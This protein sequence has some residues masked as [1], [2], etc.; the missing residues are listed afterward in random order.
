MFE[1]HQKQ[2]TECIKFQR[3]VQWQT[4]KISFHNARGIQNIHIC[5]AETNRRVD[6]TIDF[7]D[8]KLVT[9][10]LAFGLKSWWDLTFQIKFG[11]FNWEINSEFFK[12]SLEFLIVPILKIVISVVFLLSTLNSSS[13]IPH[14]TE[15]YTCIT[16]KRSALP[17]SIPNFDFPHSHSCLSLV[18]KKKIQNLF[19]DTS[20][21][22][23]NYPRLAPQ[24]LPQLGWTSRDMI[25]SQLYIIGY[26]MSHAIYT[27][28]GVRFKC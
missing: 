13:L 17:C 21:A 24:W 25:M 26:I 7:C 23:P 6:W 5:A 12:L 18:F 10:F 28:A 4:S 14:G 15:S 16:S 2:K 22:N 19:S 8:P 9:F 3:A 1:V 27:G 20:L 11:I